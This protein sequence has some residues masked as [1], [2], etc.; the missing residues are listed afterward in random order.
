VLLSRVTFSPVTGFVTLLLVVL[1]GVL[2]T[3]SP[4][5]T[6]E[7]YG[8]NTNTLIGADGIC[9][10]RAFYYQG[11]GL[12][13][14]THNVVLPDHPL[15]KRGWAARESG[16]KV[17]VVKATGMHGFF[18]GRAVHI[19]DE[20]ALADPLLARL[21]PT[22]EDWRVGHYR[23]HIPEG[24]LETLATGQNRLADADLAAYY[25]AIALIT[26]GRLFDSRRCWEIVKLNL[27]VYDHLLA[28]AATD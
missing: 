24:Y 23:R 12:L 22:L 15:A 13:V 11:T 26:R 14:A 3:R 8:M 17:V 5:T 28:T 4:L 7:D 2:P 1:I 27:G 20:L 18:A 21:P 10:E 9:D 19:V 25:D 16:D 6:G